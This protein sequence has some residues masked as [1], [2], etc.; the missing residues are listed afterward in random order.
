PKKKVVAKKVK[1]PAPKK[2]VVAKKVKKP[3]PKTKAKAKAKA[4]PRAPRPAPAKKA[5]DEEETLQLSFTEIV[6][7]IEEKQ[8]LDKLTPQ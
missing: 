2:K 6:G 8:A 4:K 3:A 1:K 7:D 5:F